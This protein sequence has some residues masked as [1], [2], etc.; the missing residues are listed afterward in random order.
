M[1]PFYLQNGSMVAPAI[2]APLVVFC[3]YGMGYGQYVGSVMKIVIYASY[4]RVGVIA[5]LSTIFDDR[6]PLECT[7][8]IICF[9]QDPQR[10][11]KDIGMANSSYTLHIIGLIAYIVLFRLLAYIALRFRLSSEVS[12]I[13]VSYISKIFRY[14]LHL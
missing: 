6:S 7:E 5:M 12:Q 11:L 3:I 13:I 10:L 4:M 8:E 9:Y 14:R 1:A 2:A